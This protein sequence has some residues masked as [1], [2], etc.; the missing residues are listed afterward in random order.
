MPA[1]PIATVTPPY[2]KV[3]TDLSYS[4]S[5]TTRAQHLI[6]AHV[7]GTY[8]FDGTIAYLR[9]WHGEALDA[10]QVAEL[11]NDRSV[12]TVT[13][14]AELSA[15]IAS[16][17]TVVLANSITLAAGGGTA[18][19]LTISGVTG[20]TI[21][22][23]GFTLGFESSLNTNG[24]IFSINSASEV[25]M[26]DLTLA[27]GYQF[28]TANVH[29]GA[30][31]ITGSSALEIISCTLSGHTSNTN[32]NLKNAYGGAIAS[33]NANVTMI[34]CTLSANT[35]RAGGDATTNGFGG[36]VYAES[37]AL[38]ISSSTLSGNDADGWDIGFG[39]AIS[40]YDSKLTM[41]TSTL[42]GNTGDGTY[43]AGR[44]G[45][46]YSTQ[47]SSTVM[48]CVFSANQVIGTL[49]N[50]QAGNGVGG[51]A[52]LHE[53]AFA[54][55]GC[56]FT[57]NTAQISA[58]DVYIASGTLTTAGSTNCESSDGTTLSTNDG[59]AYDNYNCGGTSPPTLLP[60]L[61]PTPS[62]TS[63]PC[64]EWCLVI[65]RTA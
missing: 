2:I 53:S 49:I 17:R 57:S 58:A 40:L 4:L 30:I 51:A 60:T 45:A 56:Y 26:V 37:S 42:S 38:A 15:A 12:V 22:G 44:G 54:C 46:V 48:S 52:Y 16:D 13:T 55:T 14:P 59:N 35:A 11:Y 24:R 31:Y 6:G 62:P 43:Y 61:P 47:S 41:M 33:L 32:T 10:G 5:S 19:A 29:G 50:T 28:S 39:G 1:F 18:S 36:A 65:G 21:D 9:F 63:T 23:G 7:G 8:V 25:K 34:S 3:E 64:V 20:L 27:N